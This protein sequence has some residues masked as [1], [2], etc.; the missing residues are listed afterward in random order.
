MT[1][2]R[3]GNTDLAA[4]TFGLMIKLQTVLGFPGDKFLSRLAAEN[5]SASPKEGGHDQGTR[6]SHGRDRAPEQWGVVLSLHP[7]VPLGGGFFPVVDTP[8]WVSLCP[9]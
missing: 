5:G 6:H 3:S 7:A 8:V 4:C 9:T 1:T 2:G